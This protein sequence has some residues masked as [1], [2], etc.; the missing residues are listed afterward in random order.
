[1]D[2][3]NFF[4]YMTAIHGGFKAACSPECLDFPPYRKLQLLFPAF[5]PVPPHYERE[6]K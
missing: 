3:F 4:S 6:S 2:G 5:S 1:M